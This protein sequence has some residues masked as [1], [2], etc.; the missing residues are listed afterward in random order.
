MAFNRVEAELQDVG[1]FFV[2]FSFGHQ[3]QDLFLPRRQ[4][5][6]TIFDLLFLDLAHVIFQ[7]HSANGRT[8]KRLTL[9]DRTHRLN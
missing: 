1:D 8:E 2:R 7:Q 6:V 4:Q 3:L 5:V 9:G